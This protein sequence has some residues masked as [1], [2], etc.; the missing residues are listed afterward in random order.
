M[1][2]TTVNADVGEG[3][4]S[5]AE[6]MPYLDYANIACGGHAGDEETI[7][8]SIRLALVNNVQVGAHPSYPDIENFG[9]VSLLNVLEQD[10]LVKSLTT[11][12]LLFA[13]VAED[14]A[15]QGF[16]VKPH[17][18]L[19]NDCYGSEEAANALLESVISV[20]RT[21]NLHLS[22]FPIMAQPGSRLESLVDATGGVIFREGFIDRLYRSD[23]I[24]TPRTQNGSVLH[25]ED[26]IMR[27]ILGFTKYGSIIADDGNPIAVNVDTLCIHS[28]SPKAVESAVMVRQIL[29]KEKS[30]YNAVR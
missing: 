23:G 20:A 8:N 24:L 1:A 10:S 9:R 17:G 15:L 27:Q 6:L 14:F 25:K 12:L 19:Y 28:D 7:G 5:D 26:Q 29:P 4:T 2:I 22:H 18:A 16:H 3:Y 11:Q 21:Y 30:G 13:R